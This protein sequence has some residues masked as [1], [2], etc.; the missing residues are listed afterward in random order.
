MI[1][2]AITDT[3]RKVMGLVY[4]KIF[5]ILIFFSFQILSWNEFK[6]ICKLFEEVDWF[7]VSEVTGAELNCHIQV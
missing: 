4:E 2:I 1:V 5:T 7:D 3:S 6:S